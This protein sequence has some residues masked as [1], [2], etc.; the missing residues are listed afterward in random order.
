MSA[1]RHACRATD[2]QLSAIATSVT[3]AVSPPSALEGLG[4]PCTAVQGSREP[5][6]G[7]QAAAG[8]IPAS[9]VP[10]FGNRQGMTLARRGAP[11]SQHRGITT[12]S[13]PRVS[14]LASGGDSGHLS[15]EALQQRR[16]A[17]HREDH[18]STVHFAPAM[19][20]GSIRFASYLRPSQR[21]QRAAPP[22]PASAAG[23]KSSK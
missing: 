22:P 7:R 6:D 2:A 17:V 9:L 10:R 18:S 23:T 5:R 16:H 15:G 4:T 19:V 13:A 20:V 1:A 8:L 21:R 11:A 12:R 3:W 14:C